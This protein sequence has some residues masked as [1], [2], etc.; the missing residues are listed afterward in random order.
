LRLLLTSP[1]F[2]AGA[3]LIGLV[4]GSFANVCVHRLPRG[5]S[6]VHP[7]SR[8][9][10]CLAR[11]APRDNLPVLG[12]LLLGGR[13]R[14]CAA[15]IPV[16]YPAVELANGILYLV[17]AVQRGP[18]VAALLGMVLVTGLLV[19]GL[20]DLDHQLLP[21][22][23]TLPFLV[24]GL[25]LGAA[26][27]SGE[28]PERWLSALGGLA[29]MAAAAL[30][31]GWDRRRPDPA[32]GPDW[33][34]V[35]LILVFSVWQHAVTGAASAPA[36]TAAAGYLLMAGLAAA[37]ARYYG[38]EALGQGDW[39]MVAMMGALLGAPLAMLA[40]FLGT[41]AGALSGLALI[42]LGL[43]SRRMKIPLGSFLSLGGVAALVVG[44][45]LLEWYRGL[46]GG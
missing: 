39:K 46:L 6:V 13:C 45:P 23:I 37:A 16:R 4:I 25:G 2:E 24:M 7:P 11:I 33:K 17:L 15:R 18:T 44:Q 38:Q 8:C 22:A 36:L 28:A 41:L 21:D 20:I 14:S 42:A 32:T 43:G 9:P 12:W 34:M 30:L 26:G 35:F 1:T 40:V 31:L 27:G 10:S 3:F 5:Q 29:L 19:L